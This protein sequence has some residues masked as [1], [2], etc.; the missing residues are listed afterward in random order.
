[1]NYQV[2]ARKY[3][4]NEFSSVAAQ[5]LITVSLQN[6]IKR[7]RIAHAYLFSGPRGVGKTSL[8]RIFAKALNCKD[9]KNGE[10]CGVCNNCREITA[11]I[12]LAVREIDGASHNSVDNVR[13]LIESFRMS[14]PPNCKY[15]VYIIDEVHMLS[16]SAFN[17]L[18]K[19]L[20]EPP[21]GTV[22]IL[23][24]TEVHKIPD[25]VISRCHRYDFKAIP[26]SD[27]V[28][29]LKRISEQE[30][31]KIDSASLDLIS[32]LADGS[33][34]DAESL[35]DRVASLTAEEISLTK[36]AE[37]LG[38]VNRNELFQLSQAIIDQNSAQALEILKTIFDTSN[39]IN[40]LLSEFV[41]HWRN[42]FLSSTL[43]KTELLEF[44]P[45]DS[46]TDELINQTVNESFLDIQDLYTMAMEQCDKALRSHYPQYALE[47]LIV[48]MTTRTKLVEL[49][50]LF[51]NSFQNYE[52][53]PTAKTVKNISNSPL[54][55]NKAT[56]VISEKLEVIAERD[57]VE[58]SVD[59]NWGKFVAFVEN[60]GSMMLTEKLKAVFAQIDDQKQIAISGST[61]CL[62]S[63]LKDTETADRVIKM[64]EEFTGV[65]GWRLIDGSG[66]K[67][68]SLVDE[69]IENRNNQLEQLREKIT[70]TP[71]IKTL[72]K[73]FPGSKIEKIEPI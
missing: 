63:L 33:M 71:Q 48:R 62:N 9:L 26:R 11:Q 64:A 10:P 57:R 45:N 12:S 2:L 41:D 3:R 36:T 37:I 65:R 22:F 4:P 23:A 35:L 25:T 70:N 15:K 72:Q 8:A 6:A 28:F 31:F 19:S 42:L 56:P 58:N 29:Q 13:E 46:L 44:L 55:E 61:Y 18:L 59:F 47:A 16:I 54:K 24:T 27:I 20:E 40:L 60:T 51:S 73:V 14:P 5:K 30:D 32:R 52:L 7:N 21:S 1:M 69:A 53:G 50:E 39:D 17:A 49:K 43:K 38:I 34:R 68:K 66:I 67:G